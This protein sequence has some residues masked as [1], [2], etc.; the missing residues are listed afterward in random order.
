MTKKLLVLLLIVGFVSTGVFAQ[1]S[2]PPEDNGGNGEMKIPPPAFSMDQ[3][4]AGSLLKVI[5]GDC[6]GYIAATNVKG[7]VANVERLVRQLGLGEELNRAAPAGLLQTAAMLLQLGEWYNPNGG[8]AAVIVN[9][10]KLGYDPAAMGK[11]QK[12]ETKEIPVVILV[13]G[14]SD[15]GIFPQAQ[16]LETGGISIPGFPFPVIHTAKIGDYVAFS[17]SQKALALMAGETLAATLGTTEKDLLTKNDV[18]VFYNLKVV[19][20][21]IATMMDSAA[22][23]EEG[24]FAPVGILKLYGTFLKQMDGLAFGIKLGETGILCK[25]YESFKPDSELAKVVA[26]YKPSSKPLMNRLPN[27]PYVLAIGASMAGKREGEPIAATDMQLLE[28]LLKMAD[29]DIP[30]DLMA[31][32]TKTSAEFDALLTSVQVVAGPANGEGLFG[33]SIVLGVTDAEKARAILPT[34]VDLMTQLVQ[35][36]NEQKPEEDLESLRFNYLKNAETINDSAIDVIEVT[37]DKLKTR[38]D[39]QKAEMKKVFGENG[40]DKL[41]IRVTEVDPKTLVVAVGGGKTFMAAAIDAA[42]KG[43]TI[44][45]DTGVQSTLKKLPAKPIMSLV[46]S[47]QNLFAAI[48]AG[49]VVMGEKS[50]LPEDFKFNCPEPIGIGWALADKNAV[51]GTIYIPVG[52]IKDIVGWVK[53]EMAAA[54]APIEIVEE[55]VEVIEEK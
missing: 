35:A 18:A 25:F 5:P 46:L 14:K 19:G 9:M 30:E 11:D 48:Q 26:A 41:L 55:E 51:E 37:F 28:M 17:P 52:V 34:E 36:L 6:M 24:M 50:N 23:G 1:D 3:P 2:Q 43:G 40:E 44:D 42:C 4:A 39:E 45:Q 27:L 54:F 38:T 31:K 32:I 8:I 53:A 10:E 15:I 16:K 13:A 47:P 49:M 12:P 7:L 29:L 21:F 20:P 33:I 22:E